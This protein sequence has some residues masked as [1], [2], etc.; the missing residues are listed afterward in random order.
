MKMMATQDETLQNMFRAQQLYQ[1]HLRDN[2]SF[3][4]SDMV[5]N[6]S[7]ASIRTTMTAFEFDSVIKATAV[8]QRCMRRRGDATSLL[9]L[10]LS[11][12]PTSCSGE[13]DTATTH[14]WDPAPR[15]SHRES[16]TEESLELDKDLLGAHLGGSAPPQQ[17]SASLSGSSVG[18]PYAK[19]PMISSNTESRCI[20]DQPSLRD[21]FLKRLP[22]NPEQ[23]ADASS[24]GGTTSPLCANHVSVAHKSPH[25]E[26]HDYVRRDSRERIKLKT[27]EKV[28]GTSRML[29]ETPLKANY[30]HRRSESRERIQQEVI[31]KLA[32][33]QSETPVEYGSGRMILPEPI[34][35][36]KAE[37]AKRRRNSDN[38]FYDHGIPIVHM[39]ISSRHVL[40]TA[41]WN[42]I[43]LRNLNTGEDVVK[44]RCY[45]CGTKDKCPIFSSDGAFLCAA[46][47]THNATMTTISVWNAETGARLC[48]L[49]KRLGRN[50]WVTA[51]AI[52]SNGRLIAC[53]K[54]TDE[55]HRDHKYTVWLFET[56]TGQPVGGFRLRY[57]AQTLS[58]IQRDKL[59]L[60]FCESRVEIW[61]V[62]TCTRIRVLE[63]G[64]LGFDRSIVTQDS[65][66]ICMDEGVGISM[67]DLESGF[68]M[69]RATLR[70]GTIVQ[71]AYSPG[72]GEIA[73]ACSNGLVGTWN[74][75]TGVVRKSRE[76][77]SDFEHWC[78]IAI[79]PD[80]QKV[81]YGGES[82]KVR[83]WNL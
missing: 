35:N 23:I 59:L 30:D 15:P 29:A 16:I 70:L 27:L 76:S 47:F 36:Y 51:F 41:S 74:P 39:A 82:G 11:M 50:T 10:G 19:T 55:L 79:A 44:I 5:S 6:L 31:E 68:R 46:H 78:G 20:D 77:G 13:N 83:C 71:L 72:T 54:Y 21:M 65:K 81:F 45:P 22:G 48:T 49:S 73:F 57:G 12:E 18:D 34:H 14:Q 33:I 25:R 53:A 69:A 17:V 75:S 52:C 64:G 67:F 32:Q 43:R 26:S 9:S 61:D 1:E 62:A 28:L 58:F 4:A 37:S 42:M 60:C 56:A 80:G 8:Y 63:Q 40:A 7:S 66:L 2:D 3:L 24:R 38:V